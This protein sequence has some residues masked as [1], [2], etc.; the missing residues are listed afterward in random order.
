MIQHRSAKEVKT[1]NLKSSRNIECRITEKNV[2]IISYR[3]SI[4]VVYMLVDPWVGFVWVDCAKITIF[5]WELYQMD[6]KLV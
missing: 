2:L 6:Q 4:R 5:L 3:M 1:V